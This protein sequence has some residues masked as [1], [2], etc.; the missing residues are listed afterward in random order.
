MRQAV[1]LVAHV[2]ATSLGEVWAMSL[3]TPAAWL[4]DAVDLLRS[5]PPSLRVG[6]E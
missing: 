4:R 3:R 2:Y 6:R 5:S 1:G